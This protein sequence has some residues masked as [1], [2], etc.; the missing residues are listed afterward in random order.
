ML[1]VSEYSITVFASAMNFWRVFLQSLVVATM[2]LLPIAADARVSFAGLSDELEKN[3]RALMGIAAAPCDTPEWRVRRLYRDADIQ[4]RSALEALG[5]YR[6]EMTK[7]LSLDAGDCWQAEFNVTLGEPVRIRDVSIMVDGA[8]STDTGLDTRPE[9][10]PEVGSVLN[11]GHYETYKKTLISNLS[12]RGYFD[13]EL[14]ES[15]VTVSENLQHADIKLRAVSGPRYYFGDV[16]F[17]QPILTPKLLAGYVKFKK[18]DPYDASAVSK[19]HE[20]LN[21]SGYFASVSIQAEPTAESGLEVPVNVSLSSGKRRVFTAGAGYAT[22]LGIQ[23]RLGY[24]NRRRNQRGHQFDTRLFLSSVDSEITADYRW[25]RG[26]PDSEWVDLYGG[27]LRKRTDT[28]ESDKQTFGARLTRNR[29]EKW[30]ESPYLELTREEFEVGDQLDVSRLLTPGI[31]WETTIGRTLRR[32]PDGHRINVDF[33]GSLE[34][35]LSDTTFFQV[36][37]SAKWIKTVGATRLLA[38]ADVG[39]TIKQSLDELPATVRFFAG[40]D[41]SVRGYDYETIGPVD[42][43]GDVIGGSHKVVVSLEADWEVRENWAVAI[44][45][46]SGSAFNDSD[47]D[48]NTGIGLGLRWYSPLGPIRID[49]AH[50]L[51]DPTSDYRFHITLGPDL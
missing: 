48:M 9:L 28:S 24:T 16:S 7:D 8:A 20:L 26:R 33:R 35:V 10:R 6:Y 19:L 51:D 42:V 49:V 15:R 22:D 39:A 1:T 38:R 14:S 43:D 17:S 13:A 21:G 11:H 5:Y 31:K 12:S 44:F 32:Q 2:T 34:H 46:D 27:F 47:F 36:S 45:V 23:G 4:L 30:L 37:A 40:G 50:P 18:G 3:A 29:T 41:T 25:P